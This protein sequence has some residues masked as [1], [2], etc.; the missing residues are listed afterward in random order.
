M[1]TF[2]TSGAISFSQLQSRF[3]GSN[4]ISLSEYYRNGSYVDG[5]ITTTTSTTTRQPSSGG[6]YSYNVPLYMW[7][8]YYDWY[9]NY[10][11]T[12]LHWANSPQSP[13][14][15]LYSNVSSYTTGGSTY[16]RGSFVDW[17]DYGDY[18]K[19]YRQQTS[20]TTTT[21]NINTG[22]P[23]SGTLSMNQFYGATY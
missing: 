15:T 19:I 4:P 10:E 22:I 7:S 3:G 9:G 11:Y 8:E 17:D 16:Y 6:Y 13:F 5:T 18:Y 12:T 2:Q 14:A 20:T 1:P 21:T 23:T